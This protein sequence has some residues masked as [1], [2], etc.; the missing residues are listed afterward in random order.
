MFI[1]R[2]ASCT[3]RALAL[4]FSFKDASL[5]QALTFAVH[6]RPAEGRPT[7]TPRS[8][9]TGPRR[10]PSRGAQVPMAGVGEL[11]RQVRVGALG[12]AV[13]GPGLHLLPA[14][15][16]RPRRRG[17]R[18]AS[19]RCGN[20]L[21]GHR[22]IGADVPGRVCHTCLHRSPL[23]SQPRLSRLPLEARV[24][25]RSARQ[26]MTRLGSARYAA[27]GPQGRWT[28]PK[29]KSALSSPQSTSIS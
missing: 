16:F 13:A 29:S 5:L 23:V 2:S 17:A 14:T 1:A 15:A 12:R 7:P 24:P 21:Q 4:S 3:L 9:S 11:A 19:C 18:S 20:D 6:G 22:Q 10:D 27:D 8:R 26:A 28:Q 25:S